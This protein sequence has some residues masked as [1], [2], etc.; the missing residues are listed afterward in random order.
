MT[1]LP[2]SQPNAALFQLIVCFTK[3]LIFVVVIIIMVTDR[4]ELCFC[5]KG[6]IYL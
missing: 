2:I 3:H 6:E 1:L 5:D 4:G